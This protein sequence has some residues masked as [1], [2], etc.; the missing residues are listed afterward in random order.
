MT[1][2]V[3]RNTRNQRKNAEV[4]FCYF[5]GELRDAPDA[6]RAAVNKESQPGQEE[7]YRLTKRFRVFRLFRVV[8]DDPF[9]IVASPSSF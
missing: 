4:V 7:P 3:T 5:V 9:V 2:G 8:R 6:S 1:E